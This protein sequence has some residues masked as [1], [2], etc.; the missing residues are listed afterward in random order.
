MMNKVKVISREE[1]SVKSL[2]ILTGLSVKKR[3]SY[4]S[5]TLLSL[6]YV[7]VKGREYKLLFAQC[8]HVQCV[9]R[10]IQKI[11][12]ENEFLYSL[13]VSLFM[14]GSAILLG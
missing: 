6:L 12:H 13:A 14:R 9:H 7:T 2:S 5:R 11:K 3:S 8:M 10:W 1:N 4:T